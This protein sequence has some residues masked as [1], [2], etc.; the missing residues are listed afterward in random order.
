MPILTNT[1]VEELPIR[2]YHKGFHAYLGFCNVSYERL[3]ETKNMYLHGD[4]LKHYNALEAEAHQRSYLRGRYI[5]KE[6]LAAYFEE[7]DYT[8]FNIIN[9]VFNHPIVEYVQG[10]NRTGV[11][12]T[13]NE[14]YGVSI[15]FSEELPMSV[16]IER[17]N[18]SQKEIIKSQLSPDEREL[19]ANMSWQSTVA[20]T[21]LWTVKE[22][23]SKVI[24]TGLTIPLEVLKISEFEEFENHIVCRFANFPQ[25]QTVSFRVKRDHV[26]S[27]AMPEGVVET[28]DVNNFIEQTLFSINLQSDI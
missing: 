20:Y 18:L 17:C 5:S 11:S 13:H 27:I 22:A 26:C 16:D 8:R 6:V 7:Q 21:V 23:I 4:E 1:V 9:G 25:Y 28:E 14:V 3:L 15:A 2:G 10:H 24:K 19:A 12:I